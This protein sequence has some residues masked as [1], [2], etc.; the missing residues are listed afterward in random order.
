MSL[1]VSL[2]ERGRARFLFI[3]IVAY[4]ARACNAFFVLGLR[5]LRF[6]QARVRE[7]VQNYMNEKEKPVRIF[8]IGFFELDILVFINLCQNTI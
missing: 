7:I 3:Y 2:Q 4:F 5:F 1:G 6:A 8:R